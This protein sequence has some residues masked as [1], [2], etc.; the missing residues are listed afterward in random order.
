MKKLLVEGIA[1]ESIAKGE[2]S[3]KTL[4]KMYLIEKTKIKLRKPIDTIVLIIPS[5][6]N[7][8]W[9]SSSIIIIEFSMFTKFEKQILVFKMLLPI[10]LKEAE[11]KLLILII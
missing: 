6:E 2:I 3:T 4:T 7:K 8:L 1:A 11:N 10:S 5:I 9:A